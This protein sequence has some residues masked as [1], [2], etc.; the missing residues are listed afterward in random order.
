[1]WSAVS[2]V[3]LTFFAIGV[4]VGLIAVAM[5]SFCLLAAAVVPLRQFLIFAVSCWVFLCAV[6]SCFRY[7]IRVRHT[8]TAPLN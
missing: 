1:M 2:F 6:V 4:A 3:I 5:V 7:D 8:S